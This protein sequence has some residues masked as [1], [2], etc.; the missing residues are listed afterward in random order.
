M[1]MDFLKEVGT[2][3]VALFGSLVSSCSLVSCSYVDINT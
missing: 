2:T 1:M 3:E